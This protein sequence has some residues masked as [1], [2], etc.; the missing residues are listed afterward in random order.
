MEQGGHD[1]LAAAPDPWFVGALVLG[2][3]GLVAGAYLT[4]AVRQ[5]RGG[6][7]VPRTVLFTAGV[8]IAAGSVLAGSVDGGS[9]YRAHMVAHLLVGMLAPLMMALGA[10]VTLALRTLHVVPAR[11][12]S[13]LLRLRPVSLLTHPVTA[14][15]LDMGGLWLI[16]TTDL[17]P[18]SHEVPLVGLVVQLHLVVAGYLFAAAVVGVDPAPHRPGH[19]VR[20]AVLVAAFA[21]H[22]ILAKHLVGHPPDGVDPVTAE[23]GSRIMYYGGDV[24]EIALLVLLGARWLA[25]VR[26]GR[27]GRRIVPTDAALP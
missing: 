23:A 18:M 26:P 25:S 2:V 11:R 19:G 9:G 14:G 8:A 10:P 7:P 27:G 6:W 1:H 24:V 16:Y 4:G 3:A 17:Y 13:R 12:L 20:A 22:G 15:V 5:G 21:A